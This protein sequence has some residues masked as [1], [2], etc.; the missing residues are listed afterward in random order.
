SSNNDALRG[1]NLHVRPGEIV[2][3][4]GYSGAGKSTLVDLVAGFWY[5][6]GGTLYIDGMDIRTLSLHSLRS[7]I[8]SVTQDI[9]LFDDTVKAN[10]LFGKPG[11][12]DEEVI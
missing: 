1:V 11:A 7:H 9:I 6:T 8:G 2:A 3:L 4:V 5:P 12:A 10:I